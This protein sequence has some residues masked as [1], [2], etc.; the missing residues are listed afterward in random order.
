MKMSDLS[1]LNEDGRIVKGVNTTPD[2]STDEI[3]T[4][5]QDNVQK[6]VVSRDTKQA[7]MIPMTIYINC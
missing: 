5:Q 6:Y 7:T 2:V 1:D 3:K 4:Q